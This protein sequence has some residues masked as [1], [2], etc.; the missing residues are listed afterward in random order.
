MSLFPANQ[1]LVVGFTLIESTHIKNLTLEG[2]DCRPLVWQLSNG[3]AP[4][5]LKILYISL[6]HGDSEREVCAD[7]GETRFQGQQWGSANRRIGGRLNQP[8]DLMLGF[9][10]ERP[11]GIWSKLHFPLPAVVRE[12]FPYKQINFGEMTWL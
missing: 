2:L 12:A 7:I 4:S 10:L 8:P 5:P 11:S 6:F 9:S 3:F 1:T